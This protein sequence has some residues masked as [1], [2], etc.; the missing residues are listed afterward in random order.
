MFAD[1]LRE[2]TMQVH[3]GLEKK[4]IGHIK[5]IATID[6]YVQLLVLMYGFYVPLQKK[7]EPFLVTADYP[8]SVNTGREAQ[9]ILSDIQYLTGKTPPEI[10]V[11]DHLPEIN[12][13]ASAIGSLYVTEGSTLG[14]LIIAQMISK[15]LNI[16]A[17]KGFS[18]FTAY[19]DETHQMWTGFKA[20]LN[21]D[22]SDKEKQEI[23]AIALSTFSTFKEW[24]VLYE[25]SIGAIADN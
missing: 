15:K 16:P 8:G 7:T 4:L 14:G 1:E 6:D 22:F 19:G 20:I 3:Q 18:F 21:G 2:S 11:C 24:V 17:D 5:R 23:K 12:S 10:A 13:Y 9:S 25:T